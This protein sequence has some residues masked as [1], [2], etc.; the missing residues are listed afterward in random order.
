MLGCIHRG[1]HEIGGSC[2]ELRSEGQRLLIDLGL[3]LESP[4]DSALYVP[5][6][7]GLDGSDPSLLGLLLSHPHIDHYGLLGHLSP[8][9][10]VGMGAAAR[11]IVK[12]ASPFMPGGLPSISEGW[13]YES[14][15]PFD[16]G[17]FRVTPFLVDHSA[18]D[19]YSLLVESGGRRLFYSGDFR[20]LGRKGPL[21]HKFCANP[22]SDIHAL[23]LEGTTIGRQEPRV[24]EIMVEK[25]MAELFSRTPGLVMV[26]SSMQNIDRVVSVFKAC[27]RRSRILVVDLYGAAV[28]EATG[29]R[30]IPQPVWAQI[31]LYVPRGQ[32]SKMRQQPE[33]MERLG[34]NRI[35]LSRISSNPGRFALMFR[36]MHMTDLESGQCLDG[37][38][39]V[40]SMW[41]G[42]RKRG[43][44][45]RVE[46]WLEK[47]GV[48]LHSI[49]SSGHA[50][51]GDLQKLVSALN[52]QK[53][54]PIH[55][56][57]PERYQEAFPFVEMHGDGEWW[58]V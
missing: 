55:S 35:S 8:N 45:A 28:L 37:A 52:P 47:N 34:K 38:A 30:K 49:H 1:S 29:N 24:S 26:H 12:A 41:E 6:I 23:L 33:L 16:V 4:G 18:Y 36:P 9:V 14:G 53:V 46:Q 21:F 54:I 32:L 17:P 27:I 20:S 56:F 19:A 10:P 57:S 58:E 25:R 39:L 42:Y 13:D 50:G 7:E 2:V 5:P 40:Y 11:R 43:D 15:V 44:Y 48:S 3:P 31:A 51:T 22:P